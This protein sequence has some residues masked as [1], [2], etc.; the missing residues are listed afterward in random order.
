MAWPISN[1]EKNMG[2]KSFDSQLAQAG[3]STFAKSVRK[4]SMGSS[5]VPLD[6]DMIIFGCLSSTALTCW[7]F[8]DDS[9]MTD[10]VDVLAND[11]SQYAV[12]LRR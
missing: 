8:S 4:P 11:G 5:D 1:R 12:C 9:A 10:V 2:D 3:L 7:Y 6:E